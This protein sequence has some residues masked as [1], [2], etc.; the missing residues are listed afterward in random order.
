V[1]ILEYKPAIEGL[2]N[3]CIP[4]QTTESFRAITTSNNVCRRFCW[5]CPIHYPTV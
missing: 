2:G 1:R 4:H 3:F 5:P